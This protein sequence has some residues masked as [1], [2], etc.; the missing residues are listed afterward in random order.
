M[1]LFCI[2]ALVYIEY[3]LAR[4]DSFNKAFKF[5]IVR[6]RRVWYLEVEWQVLVILIIPASQDDED[7]RLFSIAFVYAENRNKVREL[8]I[9]KRCDLLT[10]ELSNRES[11]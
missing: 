10:H 2:V 6:M 1:T 9:V 5:S 11:I 8:R 7:G 3:Q 4:I